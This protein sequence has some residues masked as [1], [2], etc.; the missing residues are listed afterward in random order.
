MNPPELSKQT[1]NKLHQYLQEQ[2]FAIPKLQRNFVWDGKKAAKLLDS[3]Y[4]NMPT[5]S[6]FLWEMDKKSAHLIRQSTDVLPSFNTANPHVWFVIDGQQ[7]L[8]VIFR[9]FEGGLVENDYGDKIN[10][11]H[12]CFVTSPPRD[13]EMPPRIVYRKPLGKEFVELRQILASNWRSNMNKH[14]QAAGFRKVVQECRER[15]LNYPL[16]VVTV[17]RASLDDIGEVFIRLNHQGTPISSVDRAIALMGALDV[18]AMAQ[19]IR[20]RVREKNFALGDIAPILMGFNLI[21][22]K[23]D[24]DGGPPKLDAMAQRWSKRIQRDDKEKQTFKKLWDQYQKAFL[25]AVDFLGDR[26]PV[27]D[28]S[29][30]PSVNMLATLAV[31]FYHHRRQPSQVQLKELRKWFWATA[32]AQRYT[33]SGYHQNIV[34]DA[35]FFEALAKGH[36]KHFAFKDLLDPTEDVQKAKYASK[37]ALSR[38]L[39]CLLAKQEPLDLDTGARITLERPVVSQAN[40]LHRHHVFPQAQMKSH[41]RASVYNSLC[42]ICLLT[43]VENEGIGMTLPR[44]YLADYRDAD[45]KR[46]RRIMKSHMIPAAADS[47]IWETGIVRA[48][49]KFQ[50]ERLRL[51]CNAFEKEA[52][53]TLFRKS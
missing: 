3:I 44:S 24:L 40:T 16:P 36:R 4:R 52:G 41:F 18:R 20:Q 22:E 15:I 5:G 46:F 13:Q 7:R 29:Y 17:R 35:I 34:A 23:L 32:V 9:A 11:D 21:T 26:F 10:F 45:L 14:T 19:E 8:S 1:I 37:S 51:I 47:G 6:L 39:F 38:A 28:E 48:F 30:L 2:R 53:I 27:Y 42:N 33:G 49:K 43:A 50:T 25:L 31:F 12:L